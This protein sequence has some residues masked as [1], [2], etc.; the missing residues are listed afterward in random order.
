VIR[1]ADSDGAQLAREAELWRRVRALNAYVLGHPDK[2]RVGQFRWRL[3]LTLTLALTALLMLWADVL[4]DAPT[5]SPDGASEGQV[6]VAEFLLKLLAAAL[7]AVCVLNRFWVLAA[8][9]MGLVAVCV[10]ASS[11]GVFDPPVPT[12]VSTPPEAVE[13][14]E[15]ME[16]KP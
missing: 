4:T 13:G 9:N 15:P 16:M 7:L 14:V 5:E 3:C 10:T 12:P 2:A 1:Q 8:L 6:I 11:M